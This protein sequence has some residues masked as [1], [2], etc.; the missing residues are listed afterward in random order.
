MHR[1]KLH[2]YVRSADLLRGY[3]RGISNAFRKQNSVVNTNEEKNTYI[4]LHAVAEQLYCTN[5]WQMLT[6]S[7]QRQYIHKN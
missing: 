1:Q 7:S 2:F 6:A 4:D 3:L 5:L